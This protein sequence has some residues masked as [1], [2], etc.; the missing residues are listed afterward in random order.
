MGLEGAALFAAG[1]L[2]LATIAGLLETRV[3]V[4]DGSLGSGFAAG[5]LDSSFA[6][7]SSETLMV[8]C[9][10]DRVEVRD[11]SSRTAIWIAKDAAKKTAS[12]R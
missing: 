3:E 11:Q 12:R 10:S 5:V 1:E 6:V 8:S 4:S 7:G 2:F 9:A